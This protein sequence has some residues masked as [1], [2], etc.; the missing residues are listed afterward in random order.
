M[1]TAFSKRLHSWTKGWRILA[2][3]AGFAVFEAITLPR[4]QAAPG[5]SIVSLDTQLFYGPEQAFATV[6]AYGEARGFWIP[7]YLTWDVANPV[8]YTLIFSML[9]SWL[10]RR[11][12]RP[13][14]SCNG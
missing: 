5:G 7:V 2:L 3:V 8:L 6:A 4:L 10:F 12:F 1:L 13:R 9:M 14:A 11:G